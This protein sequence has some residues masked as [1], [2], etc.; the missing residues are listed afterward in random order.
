[1]KRL[2]ILCNLIFALALAG[3]ADI[4]DEHVAAVVR[5]LA[6]QAPEQEGNQIR[7][8]VGMG[9][10]F[11]ITND[12]LIMTNNHVIASEL[13][14]ADHPYTYL[15][16][17]KVGDKVNVYRATFVAQDPN[18]DLAVIRCQGLT[19]TPFQFLATPVQRFQD[20]YSL[21]FP[22]VAD[23]SSISMVKLAAI[24]DKMLTEHG[25]TS[26]DVTDEVQKNNLLKDLIVPTSTKGT[27]ERLTDIKWVNE[28]VPYI[29]HS[30][31]IRGGNSGGPLL[32]GGGQVVGVV[33]DARIN[34]EGEHKGEQSRLAVQTIRVQKFL[35]TNGITGCIITDKAW[36]PPPIVIPKANIVPIIIAASLAVAVALAALLV[37]LFKARRKTGV[38][39]LLE[40]LK[41]KGINSG[42]QLLSYLGGRPRQES[43]SSRQSNGS[44]P[45]GNGWKLD[46]RTSAGKTFRIPISEGMFTNNGSRLVLGR[47]GEL[48]DLVVEDETV[49]RQHVDIRKNG[50]GFEVADRN[51]SN[52][53][54]VNGVFI[55]KP[56]EL[57]PLKP[58]DT[59]TV[60]NVKLDFNRN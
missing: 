55:R 8:A 53:T 18:A 17:Q 19:A 43:S 3:H 35:Q 25:A 40:S 37:T 10:G 22:G 12:G 14:V 51:S 34:P 60:G 42:T 46:V 44:A 31:D 32:N 7:Q 5:I 36:T 1:M 56:F 28:V 52:G 29:Q 11:V 33:G 49:S 26:L 2:L 41:D 45:E 4:T 24:L 6:L 16:L 20:V 54:A 27:V 50:K 38:T 13:N 30:C 59:L 58:G 48:C 9:T 57:T 21:G 47:S 15:V 39:D 23:D